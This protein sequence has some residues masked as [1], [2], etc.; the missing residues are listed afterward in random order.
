M[1]STGY[2]HGTCA[3]TPL[4]HFDR[5]D[6]EARI[7]I[8]SRILDGIN[9]RSSE[10]ISIK[11]SASPIATKCDIDDQALKGEEMIH[12]ARSGVEPSTGFA[13]LTQLRLAG[14]QVGRDVAFQED[15]HRNA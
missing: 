2:V 10:S 8:V 6:L 3:L 4:V 11:R 1:N 9:A 15:P 7:V 5:S 12:V 13:P 14:A